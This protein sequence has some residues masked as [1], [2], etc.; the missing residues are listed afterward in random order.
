MA[1]ISGFGQTGPWSHYMGYGP[2]IVPIAGLSSLSGY[3]GGD[4]REVGISL[5][6]PAGGITAAFAICA[7]LESRTRTGRGQHIDVSLWESTAV[8]IAEG[9]MEHALNGRQP[10]RMG[11][12]D[13]LMSPHSCFRC[14]GEEAWVTIACAN[15]DEWRAL[16]SVVDPSLADDARFADAPARKANEPALE[17]RIAAW[18]ARLDRWEVTRSLQA[19]GVPA[20]PTLTPEDLT[21]DPQLAARGF[22][23]RLDHPVVGRRIHAGIPWRLASVRGGARAPAP[24]LGAD[25]ESVLSELL[26]LAPAEIQRLSDDKVLY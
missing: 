11:N 26:G 5:G 22:L 4:P 17:E 10:A 20:F 23:E 25:T 3:P 9:W 14:A 16:C 7:A 18:T 21:L 12:R 8:L 13:P 15:E 6:D 1:S 2:A 19:V 24:V